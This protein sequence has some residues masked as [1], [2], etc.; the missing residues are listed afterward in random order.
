MA[1]NIKDKALNML[2][3]L[4]RVT[5]ANIRDNPESKKCVSTK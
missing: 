3:T 4:P 5:L 1:N 2:R